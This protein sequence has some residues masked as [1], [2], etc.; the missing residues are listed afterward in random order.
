MLPIGAR[1]RFEVG[2]GAER[3]LRAT[4]AEQLGTLAGRSA[5][6]AVLTLGHLVKQIT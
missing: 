4:A 5:L 2:E 6:V 1:G 3:L